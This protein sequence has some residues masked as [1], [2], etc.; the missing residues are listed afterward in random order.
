MDNFNFKNF[1][2]YGSGCRRGLDV[3]QQGHSLKQGE[4]YREEYKLMMTVN[5]NTA[6]P[7]L[8]QQSSAH[9]QNGNQKLS[10]EM[11]HRGDGAMD[12]WKSPGEMVY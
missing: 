5:Y 10:H 8:S 2:T 12:G 7:V 11:I 9:L 6:L 4:S 3:A 1:L